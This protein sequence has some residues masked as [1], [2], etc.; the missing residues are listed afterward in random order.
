MAE[1]T[2]PQSPPPA[3]GSLLAQGRDIA[4]NLAGAGVNQVK[5]QLDDR[6]VGLAVG[7]LDVSQALLLTGNQM[8]DQG[9]P[10]MAEYAAQI[11]ER[12]GNAS[13]T[14]RQ[15]DI[16]ALLNDAQNFARRQPGLVLGGAVLIGLVSARLVKSGSQAAAAATKTVPQDVAPSTAPF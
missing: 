8:R 2:Q 9:Q 3:A 7:L 10:R 6:K 1:T 16:N 12:L 5:K 4:A 14:L 11:A 15:R 13:G